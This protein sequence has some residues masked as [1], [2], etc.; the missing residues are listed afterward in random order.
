MG[1][2]WSN[3]H[4]VFLNRKFVIFSLSKLSLIF[5]TYVQTTTA[6]LRSVVTRIKRILSTICR[7]T[8]YL[9]IPTYP[10]LW[11]RGCWY[12][13]ERSKK[14]FQVLTQRKIYSMTEKYSTFRSKWNLIFNFLSWNRNFFFGYHY[15]IIKSYLPLKH[16]W[17]K[18]EK[19]LNWLYQYFISKKV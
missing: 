11:F 5:S 7:S 18:S 2:L 14:Y 13:F 10:C 1:P 19:F 15:V 3:G 12:S 17:P 4:E 9:E 6:V 16:D 8:T